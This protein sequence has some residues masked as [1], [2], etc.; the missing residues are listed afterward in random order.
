MGTGERAR[1]GGEIVA[2]RDA[3]L[4]APSAYRRERGREGRVFNMKTPPV[5]ETESAIVRP[6]ELKDGACAASAQ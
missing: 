6:G 2:L 3:S 4:K 5:P 1:G